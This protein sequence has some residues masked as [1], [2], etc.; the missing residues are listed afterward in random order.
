M[1]GKN[2]VQCC[3]SFATL[4]CGDKCENETRECLRDYEKCPSKEL[5]DV[6]SSLPL[7]DY[8]KFY[9]LCV[10]LPNYVVTRLAQLTKD[11]I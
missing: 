3:H 1:F 7:L 8:I 9:S 5:C 6:I 4:S 11:E 10:L 2:V